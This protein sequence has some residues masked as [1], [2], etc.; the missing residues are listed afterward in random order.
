MRA[1]LL[2]GCALVACLGCGSGKFVPVSGKVTL[3]DQP[4]AGATVSFEPLTEPGGRPP[5]PSSLGKTDP[6]GEFHLQ[7]PDGENGA[8]VGKHRVRI[9]LIGEEAT[10][11][12]RPRGGSVAEK[13]P[14]K[15]NTDSDMTFDVPPGGTKE[16]VFK[17]T[18]T[19]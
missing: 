10:G 7:T 16:A 15:F 13:L 9:S 11:D 17:L 12:E 4:L 18:S 1:R 8:A 19:P 2:L 14:R 3:N 6:N 5:P